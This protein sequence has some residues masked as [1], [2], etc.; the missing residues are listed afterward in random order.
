VGDQLAAV[1]LDE[2]RESG[3]VTGPCGLQELLRLFLSSL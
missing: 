1:A 3:L 2:G